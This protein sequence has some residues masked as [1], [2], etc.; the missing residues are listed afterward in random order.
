MLSDKT[1]LNKSGTC[2]RTS[3]VEPSSQTPKRVYNSSDD[4]NEQ[5][6]KYSD[7]EHAKDGG[8]KVNERDESFCFVS[9][10]HAFK[11]QAQHEHD[12]HKVHEKHK[13]VVKLCCFE[14]WG[15]VCFAEY[16]PKE[17]VAECKHGNVNCK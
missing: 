13:G 3:H 8:A 10:V 16:F 15:N 2:N 6:Y 11:Y 5:D 14:I 7:C 1:V 12:V 9:E 17:P 4:I